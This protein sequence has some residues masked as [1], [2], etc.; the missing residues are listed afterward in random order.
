MMIHNK[1]G[2]GTTSSLVVLRQAICY[3]STQVVWSKM[4]LF[5]I[6]LPSSSACTAHSPYPPNKYVESSFFNNAASNVEARIL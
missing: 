5:N 1:I 2:V 3:V 6:S 4:S